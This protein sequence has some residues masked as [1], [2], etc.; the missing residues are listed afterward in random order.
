MFVRIIPSG[1]VYRFPQLQRLDRIL[2]KV[3]LIRLFAREAILVLQK[4]D[5]TAEHGPHPEG[6]GP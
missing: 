5:P 6:E 4:E 3:P 2:E 1:Y